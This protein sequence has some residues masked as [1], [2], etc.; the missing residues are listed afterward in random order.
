MKRLL[1]VLLPIVAAAALVLGV[2]QARADMCLGGGSDPPDNSDG[3]P[4]NDGGD[5]RNRSK[6]PRQLG[7]G[8]LLAACVSSGWLCFRRKGP[9][10]EK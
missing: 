4:S 5:A 10:A 8:F 2:R 6:L 1:A 3:A 7:A 9:G